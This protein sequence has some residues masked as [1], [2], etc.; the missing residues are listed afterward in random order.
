MNPENELREICIDFD[1]TVANNGPHPD[2][3][4]LEPIKGAKEALESLY[5]N[6]WHI[7]IYT[8]RSWHYYNTI[9]EYMDKHQ[10][11]YDNVVCGKMFA[12][13]YIDDRGLRF[14]SWDQTMRELSQLEGEIHD[15]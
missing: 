7:T 13:Y 6:G 1:K 9:R 4:I 3:E 5:L 10:L 8:A 11:P 2:Y 15:K 14:T 12:K